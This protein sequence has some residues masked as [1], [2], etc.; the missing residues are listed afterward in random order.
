MDSGNQPPSSQPVKRRRITRACDRCH[1]GSLKCAPGPTPQSCQPCASYGAECKFDRPLKRRGPAARSRTDKVTSQLQRQSPTY[2]LVMGTGS[3]WEYSQVADAS[4]IE[5]LAD[6]YHQIVY[7]ILLYFHWPSFYADIV[8]RRYLSD[9]S[10]YTLTIAVC[11]TAAT[12]LSG[13]LPPRIASVIKIRNNSSLSG[14]FYTACI[15]ALPV[16]HTDEVEFNFM[17]TEALLGMLCL[18]YNNIRGCHAHLHRYLAMCAE[19]GFNDESKWPPGLTA[20]EVEERRRLFWQQY[21]FDVYLATIFGSS[22][23]QRGQTQCQVLYPAEVYDDSDIGETDVHLRGDDHVS[24]IRGWNFVT[25]LYRILEHFIQ[26]AHPQSS[27]QARRGSLMDKLLSS[28]TNPDTS[29]VANIL[30]VSQEMYDSLPVE[31]RE[32]RPLTGQIHQD[33]YGF[34]AINATIT[35][36]TLKMVL[37]RTEDRSVNQLCTMAGSFLD[38]LL[39]I[40]AAYIRSASTAMIHL[41]AGVGHI[42]G[43]VIT[44]PLSQWTFI[45]VRSALLAMAD[46]ISSL[47]TAIKSSSGIALRLRNHV[48]RIDTY[49]T[50]AVKNSRRNQ[51]IHSAIPSTDPRLL[52][53]QNDSLSEQE[54]LLQEQEFPLHSSDARQDNAFTSNSDIGLNRTQN[55]VINGPIFEGFNFQLPDELSL[56]WPFCASQGEPFTFSGNNTRQGPS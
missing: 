45:Q 6:Q 7:P 32:A 9:R 56:E 2:S 8:A 40:P 41:L 4:V 24:F 38:E 54:T 49:M 31:L 29:N 55:A 51:V 26:K 27:Q 23:R 13:E 28:N 25:D 43:Y 12:R 16:L 48:A 33:R 30:A 50:E 20:I 52:F 46:L 15:N 36:T 3:P 22:I 53:A 39:T 17:R 42:L 34:Q 44:A 18:E 1:H 19:I 47:E 10:F 21:H 35:L 5:Y 14:I 11:A 37:A